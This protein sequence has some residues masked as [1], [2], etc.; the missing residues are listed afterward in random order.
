[1]LYYNALTRTHWTLNRA[2][3]TPFHLT[4]Y[5]NVHVITCWIIHTH[6]WTSWWISRYFA[7]LIEY[8]LIILW[9]ELFHQLNNMI[10][11]TNNGIDKSPQTH[12]SKQNEKGKQKEN[13]WFVHHLLERHERK[14][15]SS[16]YFEMR[17]YFDGISQHHQINQ[18]RIDHGI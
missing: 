6:L 3:W 17:N 15:T 4:W 12:P 2:T 9:C 5:T 16:I 18:I 14:Q 13:R 8:P 7:R 11:G 10:I 1:M